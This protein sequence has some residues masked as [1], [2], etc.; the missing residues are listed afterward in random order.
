MKIH[1]RLAS[2][3]VL[4]FLFSGYAMSSPERGADTASQ[5]KT[6]AAPMDAG[7]RAADPA[8]ARGKAAYERGHFSAAIRACEEGLGEVEASVLN[9]LGLIDHAR[10]QFPAAIRHYQQALAIWQ[11]RNARANA[12]DT[13]QNL[14]CAW[15]ARHDPRLAIFCGKQAVNL[16]QEIRAD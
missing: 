9:N 15:S 6:V 11:S 7:Q 12:A 14:M 13:F 4:P 1:T 8:A 5:A 2:S 16:Y 10:D 3:V